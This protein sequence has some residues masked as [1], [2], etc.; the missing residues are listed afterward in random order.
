MENKYRKNEMNKSYKYYL[1]K[2][3]N[4][5][6]KAKIILITKIKK[7]NKRIKKKLNI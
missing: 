4:L 7:K 1:K 6:I 2:N 3:N 5:P